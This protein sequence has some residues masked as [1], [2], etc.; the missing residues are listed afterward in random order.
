MERRGP[1]VPLADIVEHRRRALGISDDTLAALRRPVWGRER[2]LR[3]LLIYLV[4]RSGGFPLES[5]GAYFSLGYTTVVNARKRGADRLRKD[6][7]L[8]RGLRALNDR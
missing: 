2:P 3:D 5:V 8:R 6:R 7:G 4:W 1:G